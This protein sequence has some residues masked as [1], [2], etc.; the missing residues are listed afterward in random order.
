M[1]ARRSPGAAVDANA[2]H[3]FTLCVVARVAASRGAVEGGS[4]GWKSSDS[5]GGGGG[6][7]CRRRRRG[8]RDRLPRLFSFERCFWVASRLG[9][10]DRRGW[11]SRSGITDRPGRSPGTPASSSDDDDD[12]AS[13][14]ASSSARRVARAAS[15]DMPLGF[16]S[17]TQNERV[18]DQKNQ[19]RSLSLSHSPPLFASAPSPSP[20][21]PP[22]WYAQTRGLFCPPFGHELLAQ[23]L[24]RR[25]RPPP[26]RPTLA[27]GR[28]AAVG[29]PPPTPRLPP[30][31]RPI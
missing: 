6:D 21:H 24:A 13:A 10:R 4:G 30:S 1:A 25:R 2:I 29:P 18:F 12:A 28:R 16:G 9:E 5:G 3:A 20:Q 14:A 8:D 11:R 22:P 7:A 15:K 27:I 31:R 26:A 17:E 19:R 23:P